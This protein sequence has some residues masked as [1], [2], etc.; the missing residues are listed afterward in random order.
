M[1]TSSLR[2]PSGVAGDWD[3]RVARE[4]ARQREIEAAFD[5]AEACERLGELRLALNWLERARELSGGL[6][7]G[8]AAQRARLVRALAGGDR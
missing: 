1:S 2:S 6:S 4:V 5:R 8:C 7:P 3:A